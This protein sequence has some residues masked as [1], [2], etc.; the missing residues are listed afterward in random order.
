M[1]DSNY[2]LLD[3][4]TKGNK[5]NNNLIPL[6]F[7]HDSIYVNKLETSMNRKYVMIILPVRPDLKVIRVAQRYR[8]NIN[9]ELGLSRN[10]TKSNCSTVVCSTDSNDNVVATSLVRRPVA[11]Q[12]LLSD[13]TQAQQHQPRQPAWN[14]STRSLD[15]WLCPC[16]DTRLISYRKS[17]RLW[18]R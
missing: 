13:G 11:L 12:R 1:S 9:T 15:L 14:H 6:C 17:V 8:I 3:A 10:Y 16:W 18:H 7:N 4:P 2:L 5:N